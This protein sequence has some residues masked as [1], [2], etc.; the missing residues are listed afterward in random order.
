MTFYEEMK[1]VA[2]DLLGEFGQG[3]VTLTRSTPGAVDPEHP[4]IF[5]EVTTETYELDAVVRGVSQKH[6]DG[7]AIVAGDLV[8]TCS[9]LA[10]HTLSDGEAADGAVVDIS[11]EMTDTIAIDGAVKTVKKISP[12]PAAGTPAVFM[13]F[14]A[15]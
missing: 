13:I 7:T 3:T 12:I 9:P 5:P 4:E 14:I 15:G 10:R 6:I 2:V 11:P 1:G 8:A